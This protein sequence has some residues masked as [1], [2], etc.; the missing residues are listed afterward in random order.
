[1][2]VPILTLLV[3]LDP[4]ALLREAKASNTVSM[5]VLRD[6]QPAVSYQPGKKTLVHSVSKV[7][8]GLAAACLLSDGKLSS[9]DVPLSSQFPELTRTPKGAVTLRQ[10]LGHVSGIQDAK[11]EKG[12]NLQEFNAT[13]DKLAY[14]LR[15]PLVETPGTTYRY[16]NVGVVHAGAL[17]ERLTKEPL[18]D[19]LRRRLLRPM[20][21][22]SDEWMKD[23][24]GRAMH[25]TG[26]IISAE[27]LVKIG[28]LVLDEGMWRGQRLIDPAIMREFTRQPSFPEANQGMGLFWFLQPTATPGRPVMIQHS[29]DGGNW[30][31]IFPELR[32]VAA[33]TREMGGK[34]TMES[35][36]PSIYKQFQP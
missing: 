27:D 24:A 5:V 31:V 3:A 13:P 35:F 1:M 36:P 8:V 14:A 7:F 16:N 32:V 6:G 29:G 19:Y 25:F 15:M 20:G 34:D 22:R 2:W 9:L 18:P 21:I 28:Q 10:L 4:D 11:D 30:L 33:R 26:L 12:S 17:L 23:K